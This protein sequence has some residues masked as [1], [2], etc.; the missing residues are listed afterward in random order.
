MKLT[1]QRIAIQ[2]LWMAL[3]VVMVRLVLQI[4]FGNHS[5]LALSSN[6]RGGLQLAGWVLAFGVLNL[7]IDFRK[8]L[9]RTP[10]K[11]RNAT[12]AL[13]IALSMI[14]SVVEV[15]ARVRNASRLR[16]HSRGFRLVRSVA[17]P[18][19]SMAV[20]Q[21][22]NLADSIET[23]SYSKSSPTGISQSGLIFAYRNEKPVLAGIDF[24]AT[25][26]TLTLIY[27][28]TGCGKS[29]LLKV[30]QAKTPGASLVGQHPRETFVAE[31]VFDELA[32]APRQ[33]NKNSDE[34]QEVVFNLCKEFEL[35]PKA[36]LQE[37]SAGWQQRVAIAAALSSGTKVLL[38]D[39]PFSALDRSGSELLLDALEKLKNRQVTIV[40]VEHRTRELQGL[41]DSSLELSGGK[42]TEQKPKNLRLQISKPTT[43]S[44]TALLGANG[45]GK[46]TYLNELA[47]T[48]GVLVP[49][50]ASDLLF[51]DTVKAELQQSDFDAKARPNSTRNIFQAFVSDFD[52]L[53]NPRDLS[54]GQKLALAI[55]I[56][57]AKKADYLM[58]DE[59]TLGL[60]LTTRQH[61]AEQLVNLAETGVELLI[62]TH[63]SDFAKA[64][65]T[66]TVHMSQVVT[67]AE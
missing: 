17:V 12:S 63:D 46:T 41:T 31:T 34:V 42:L 5:I 44:I 58:L 22:I 43:G 28:A 36:Q 52:E 64:I 56:Q 48:R 61:L 39:E 8:L 35:N 25:P 47:K 62:A 33:Q 20:D 2:Y 11:F 54:E 32:Y 16:S 1:K 4:I 14:P 9:T 51:L 59:P 10:G 37:L 24:E 30:L 18:V 29:T 53:Q 67:R 57:F 50:P 21:A 66:N 7:F 49:Q 13:T 65:A 15:A 55:S 26:G 6:L 27:G 45:S 40:V 38:L 19:V 3:L 60:D 23:R